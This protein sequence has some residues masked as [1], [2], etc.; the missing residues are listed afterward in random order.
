MKKLAVGLTIAVALSLGFFAREIIAQSCTLTPNLGLCKGARGAAEWDTFLNSNFDLI[1]SLTLNTTSGAQTKS[2]TLTLSSSTPLKL[3]GGSFA[4]ND[5]LF[6]NASKELSRSSSL[7]WSGTAFTVGSA[8]L[9]SAGAATI[10]GFLMATGAGAGKVLT[11]D[12]S[13]NGTWQT[14]GGTA[15]G[16]TPGSGIV[17]LTTSGDEVGIGV[18]S[19]TEKLEVSG[20]IK[21]GAA[22]TTQAGVIQWNGSNFQGYTGSTWTNLDETAASAGGW[23]D[24]GSTVALSSITDYVGIGASG[25]AGYKLTVGGST[26]NVGLYVSNVGTSVNVPTIWGGTQFNNVALTHTMLL[27]EVNDTASA[28]GSKLMEFIVGGASKFALRKDGQLTLAAGLV[29]TTGTFSGALEATTIKLSTGAAAGYVLTSDASGNG[30]WQASG[31]G[32][33]VPSGMI[34][35][36]DASCPSGWTRVSAFDSKFLYG[37]A[38]YGATSGAST[39]S[40]TVNPTAFSTGVDGS[41]GHTVPMGTFT[42][43]V[44]NSSETA[45]QYT[46]DKNVADAMHTHEITIAD[47]TI[48]SSGTHTHSI[49]VPIT[50]SSTE[51]TLPPYITVVY[52]KK[53]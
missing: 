1:D 25:F 36:F 39:H 20:G 33:G 22:A 11:S 44:E 34:A 52:C 27:F 31:A 49:D 8:S 47:R 16:W 29:A 21:V 6:L 18:A 35:V 3:T 46:L 50:T 4:A 37:G 38:A 41:H 2:G 5:I 42:T 26:D 32:V 17:T 48:S 14:V 15:S 10:T 13:G 28:S 51:S 19:P 43:G 23:T 45:S 30:S 12:G 40:H 7:T 53:N 24:F 9:S